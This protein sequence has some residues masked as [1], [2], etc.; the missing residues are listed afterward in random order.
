MSELVD[1]AGV[2]RAT[3]KFYLREGLLTPGVGPTPDAPTAAADYTE[4]HLERVQLIR[5][6]TGASLPIGRIRTVLDALDATSETL[7]P[8]MGRALRALPPYLDE[9]D[10]PLRALRILQRSGQTVDGPA[11]RQLEHALRAADA[12]GV[13]LSDDDVVN[14][15]RAV[16]VIAEGE[17]ARVAEQGDPRSAVRFAVLGTVLYEPVIAALRRL[18]HQDLARADSLDSTPD[19]TSENP[20]TD[21]SDT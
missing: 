16:R 2:P 5:A 9:S 4:D 13:P 18:A 15:A 12:A 7:Y 17:W 19:T 21:S 1:R 8:A 20:T 10:E 11:A 6:L 3:I 14:Y